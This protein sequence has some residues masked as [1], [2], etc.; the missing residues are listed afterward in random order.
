MENIVK[1]TLPPTCVR[2]LNRSASIICSRRGCDE[3]ISD[4]SPR[5]TIDYICV[6]ITNA[7]GPELWMLVLYWLQEQNSGDGKRGPKRTRPKSE[8]ST[9]YLYR[10]PIART[11]A[12]LDDRSLMILSNLKTYSCK[13]EVT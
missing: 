6:S 8:L 11:E 9:T 13:H 10:N 2:V 1:S 7:W 5:R 3:S 4:I 12:D